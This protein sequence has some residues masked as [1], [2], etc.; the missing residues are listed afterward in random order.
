MTAMLRITLG[1][2]I[3]GTA[4]TLQYT[5]DGKYGKWADWKVSGIYKK[6]IEDVF[7]TDTVYSGGYN[8]VVKVIKD[9]IAGNPDEGFVNDILSWVATCM[10]LR[11]DEVFS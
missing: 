7:M 1:I 11:R 8:E 3:D 10:N 5:Y 6:L 9:K 4:E 2:N